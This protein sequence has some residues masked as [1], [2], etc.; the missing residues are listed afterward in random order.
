MDRPCINGKI[1]A[2]ILG[3][4]DKV[5]ALYKAGAKQKYVK[6]TTQI[7]KIKKKGKRIYFVHK[8]NEIKVKV[9]GKRTKVMIKGEKVK[10]KKLKVGMTCKFKFPGAGGEAKYIKCK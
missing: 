4:S 8:G 2:S 9:S 7:T 3:A 5:I 6:H 1:N 10:R